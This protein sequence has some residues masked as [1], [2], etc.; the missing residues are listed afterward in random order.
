MGVPFAG[1]LLP[2]IAEKVEAEQL[3]GHCLDV[4]PVGSFFNQ[5]ETFNELLTRTRQRLIGIRAHQ[6]FSVEKAVDWCNIQ[7]GR[8]VLPQD[9]IVFNHSDDPPLTYGE[10]DVVADYPPRSYL[11][12]DVLVNIREFDDHL[13]IT[14]DFNSFK[15]QYATVSAWLQQWKKIITENWSLEQA[16]GKLSLLES[17]P[18]N[19]DGKS[20][21]GLLSLDGD[22]PPVPGARLGK[23]PAGKPAWYVADPENS[24]NY[25]LL[26]ELKDSQDCNYSTQ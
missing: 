20:S 24:G 21:S 6:F 14:L 12:A 26:E 23:N 10:L 16:N 1:Q 4:L 13:E 15:W 2:A 11:Y 9:V 25:L 18:D 19:G 5:G 7:E 17:S 22:F 3:V 8:C